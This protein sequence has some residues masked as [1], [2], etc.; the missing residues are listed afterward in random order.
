[1][2]KKLN[3]LPS[4]K[5]L[6]KLKSNKTQMD[7]DSN[8][9]YPSALW[10]ENS[11]Y[12]KMATAFVF[13]PYMNDEYVEA[14]NNQ[15]FNEGGD[16][17]AKLTIKNYNPPDVIFKHL[18]FTE[19]VKKIEVNR[20]RKSFINDPLTSVDNQEIVKTVGNVIEFYEGVIYRENFKVS[21]FKKVLENFFASG[22]K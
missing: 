15:T 12:P 10:D 20:M 22:Q 14:L 8:S 13:K 7:V 21:P 16:K 1:M 18:P 19:K 3:M 5:A 17:F 9:L 6:S 2:N 11:V 4:H